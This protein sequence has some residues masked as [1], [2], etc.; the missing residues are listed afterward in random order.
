MKDIAG[1]TFTRDTVIE[2][3]A[4]NTEARTAEISFASEEPIRDFDFAPP[5]VLL[6]ERQAV[7]FELFRSVGSVL[8]NHDK[9]Q[10]VGV[11]TEAFLDEANRKSRGTIRFGKDADSDVV[12]QKVADGILRG[13]SLRFQATKGQQ[14][15]EGETWTSPAGRTF[16]GPIIVATQWEPREVSL[17]PVPADGTVGVGRSL[18]GDDKTLADRQSRANMLRFSTNDPTQFTFTDNTDNQPITTGG[19]RAMAKEATI[20]TKLKAV[21]VARGLKDDATDAEA[22]E[23]V[24]GL[25]SEDEVRNTLETKVESEAMVAKSEERKRWTELRRLA[26]HA[27]APDLL[28]DWIEKGTSVA[29][30]RDVLLERV[31]ERNKPVSRPGATIEFVEDER[32]KVNAANEAWMCQRIA[33]TTASLAGME[34]DEKACADM[35]GDMPLAEL[36]RRTLLREGLKEAQR[37]TRPQIVTSFF[38]SRAASMG[39]G[40]FTNILENVSNKSAAAGFEQAEVTYP[41]W[42]GT[43][44]LPDFKTASRAKLSEVAD[45]VA[46]PE[47]MPVIETVMQDTKETW[48]LVTYTNRLSLTRQAIINDDLSALSRIP[49]SIGQAAARSVD[50]TVYAILTTNALMNEDGKALF[51]GDHTSGDNDDTTALSLAALT[52]GRIKMRKQTGLH[53]DKPQIDVIARHMLVPVDLETTAFQIVN[54]VFIPTAETGA[55]AAWVGQINIV[56]TPQLTGATGWYLAADPGR[57]DTVVVAGLGSTSVAPQLVRRDDGVMGVS[58]DV[59][60]DAAV[61]ALEHRGLYRGNV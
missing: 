8:V 30:A 41:Q 23:F 26:E 55:R 44:V 32:D 13:V 5:I 51:A 39:T 46:T 61:A 7:D 10:I 3:Q 47:F 27:D 21:L 40:D 19:N 16:D 14:V 50:K 1:K 18:P 25:R 37:M 57:L 58:F 56:S 45:F 38:G 2:R 60:F 54:G 12:F 49:Q 33:R 59:F 48:S 43:G 17:T 42:T 31:L 20:D 36:C 24:K 35:P 29:A 53:A 28:N 9:D 52:T 22:M 6:H 15:G 34:Y 11:P 4:V